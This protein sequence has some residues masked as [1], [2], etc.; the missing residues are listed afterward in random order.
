LTLRSRILRWLF[1][2]IPLRDLAP[3]LPEPEEAE[4]EPTALAACSCRACTL[5]MGAHLAPPFPHVR[6]VGDW[7]RRARWRERDDW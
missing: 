5:R 7:A 1:P 2:G 3:D 4:E 6:V